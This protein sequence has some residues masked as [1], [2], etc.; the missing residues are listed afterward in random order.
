M[1]AKFKILIFVLPLIAALCLL[2]AIG[3]TQATPRGSI[4]DAATNADLHQVALL[5][6]NGDGIDGTDAFGRTPLTA[7]IGHP[8]IAR[9]LLD[10]GANPNLPDAQNE[11]PL[12]LAVSRSD[13]DSIGLLIARG[14][15]LNARTSLGDT[16]LMLAVDGGFDASAIE[17]LKHGA[18][19]N[20]INVVGAT[21]LH[22]AAGR[23]NLE[24]MAALIKAG[25]RFSVKSWIGVTPL[26]RAVLNGQVKAVELL[27]KS[28][29]RPESKEYSLMHY[30]AIIGALPTQL[31]LII[32][33]HTDR[34]FNESIMNQ[35]RQAYASSVVKQ[36]E[37]SAGMVDRLCAL[38]LDIEV[39]DRHGRTPLHLA[40]MADSSPAVRALIRAG[41]DRAAKDEN[42][43]TPLDLARIHSASE[44]AAV[45]E[46]RF[47]P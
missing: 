5:L 44:A 38:G 24:L 37:L 29:A 36:E 28:G 13:L 16:S 3:L 12:E 40:A 43:Q 35:T 6:G 8:E 27:W 15:R 41:A 20:V 39:R 26:E 17:L 22:Y 9:Y 10:R 23:G 2:R 47:K 46:T 30:A 45:L 25:A 1:L 34:R 18:N 14:A 33:P 42:G 21:P 32:E 4:C 7:S 31:K 19:P 11:L